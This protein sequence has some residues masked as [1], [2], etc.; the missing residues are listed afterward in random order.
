MTI[1]LHMRPERRFLHIKGSGVH[2]DF[3]IVVAQKN[4]K[5]KAP[6][7]PL[8]LAIVLDRSGSMEGSKI[9]TAK[10][11]A[12]TL[13]DQLNERDQIALVV[14]DDRIDT[15]QALT[16]VTPAVKTEIRKQL[17]RV[18]ARGATALY[19]GWLT[20]CNAIAGDT[21]P[22]QKQGLSRCFLLTDGLANQG[23]TDT[24]QIAMQASGIRANAGISTSTFGIGN[25]YNE[26]LLGPMA[27][28][29]GG[30]FHHLRT[31]DEIVNT[32]MGELNELFSVLVTQVHL[33]IKTDAGVQTE[34]ISAYWNERAQPAFQSIAVGDL[35]GEEV[36]HVV[37]HA[38]FPEQQE[39]K[40]G[41]EVQARLV[42]QENG[43]KHQSE[44]QGTWLSYA[45]EDMCQR[46][47]PDPQVVQ[48]VGE[49]KADQAKREALKRQQQNDQAGAQQALQAAQSYIQS[50]VAYSPQLREEA[51][52]MD[53]MG[54]EM[55]RA[56]SPQAPPRMK[57]MYYQS[58]KR[59]RS[60]RD[61]R[62]PDA[63]DAKNPEDPASKDPKKK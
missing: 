18:K 26:L 28:A 57:E 1:T 9:V 16:K 39:H 12:L 43:E 56:P 47:L 6:R 29:G 21:L 41:Q 13:V 63:K 34:L 22:E 17:G 20:G 44:W 3:Q 33:E 36:R 15:I 40:D 48:Q 31:A 53:W 7:T 5:D 2:I 25:D 61:L 59:S 51:D 14:Y 19:E 50:N 4:E 32:F 60:Q 45:D 27:V 49:Q 10:S 54:Q 30:Q 23:L 38:V 46:E 35:L 58:Q 37:V 62:N 11:A 55:E 42:W 52:D 8:T 24:E